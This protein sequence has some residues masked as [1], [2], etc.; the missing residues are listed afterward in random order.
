[1]TVGKRQCARNCPRSEWREKRHGRTRTLKRFFP[2]Y[3]NPAWGARENTASH[4]LSK[5]YPEIPL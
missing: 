5:D 3:K 1:M 4:T 2:V